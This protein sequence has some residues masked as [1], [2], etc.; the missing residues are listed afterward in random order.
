MKLI[1]TILIISFAFLATC[2]FAHAQTE[3]E[4]SGQRLDKVL[5]ILQSRDVEIADL[6][7]VI[8]KLQ[9]SQ[10]TPCSI[11]VDATSKDLINWLE[12]Y[13]AANDI[14]RPEV[15]KVLK[16]KR[17]EAA[18]IVK[19]QCNITEKSAGG[20]IFDAVKTYAPILAL[21]WLRK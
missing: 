9:Q 12:R 6:K 3:L 1:K 19:T 11:S 18:R 4:I 16:L 8:A 14:S 13:G 2:Q 17:K 20:K 5:T 21:I 15:K 7:N 10:Q